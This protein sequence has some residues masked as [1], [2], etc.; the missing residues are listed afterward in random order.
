MNVKKEID[1]LGLNENEH[2]ATSTYPGTA[3]VVLRGKSLALSAFIK[4][5]V[6]TH[7]TYQLNRILKALEQKEIIIQEV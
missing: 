7:T 5:S 3:K 6:R 1:F 2:T 4:K